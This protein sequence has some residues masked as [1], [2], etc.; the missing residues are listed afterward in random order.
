MATKTFSRSTTENLILWRKK[1]NQTFRNLSKIYVKSKA[2]TTKQ[3]KGLSSPFNRKNF[4][5]NM[6]LEYSI[7]SW[8]WCNMDI[9]IA[10]LA[11]IW[12]LCLCGPDCNPGMCLSSFYQYGLL[13]AQLLL[14]GLQSRDLPQDWTM[15]EIPLRRIGMCLFLLIPLVL[16]VL[17]V[18]AF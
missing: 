14:K 18:Q 6:D 13:Q 10:V 2:T 9:I 8:V 5:S 15:I 12:V 17:L 11:C 7:L 4:F 1:I 16:L 3:K